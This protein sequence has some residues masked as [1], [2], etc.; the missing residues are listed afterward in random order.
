MTILIGAAAGCSAPTGDVVDQPQPTQSSQPPPSAPQS[1]PNGGDEPF[2]IVDFITATPSTASPG[3]R[4]LLS[5]DPPDR[6]RSCCVSVFDI[7]DPER[8]LFV[9]SLAPPGS[10]RPG[11][12]DDRRLPNLPPLTHPDILFNGPAGNQ[13]QLPD[14]VDPGTYALCNSVFDSRENCLILVVTG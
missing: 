6:G 3:D 1:L 10:D 9:M 8:L 14:D 5:Y 2:T 11:R 7:D 4:L 12:I 13:V